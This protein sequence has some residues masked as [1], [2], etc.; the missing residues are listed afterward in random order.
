M[1]YFGY[2]ITPVPGK[3]DALIQANGRFRK[4]IESH[5]GQADSG[6]Q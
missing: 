3:R 2:Q 4:I 6:L 5:G 1:V